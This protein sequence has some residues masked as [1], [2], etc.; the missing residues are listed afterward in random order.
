MSFDN[1][2]FKHDKNNQSYKLTFEYAKKNYGIYLD[3]Y[4]INEK[5]NTA[6][7]YICNLQTHRCEL[8]Y[9]PMND[10]GIKKIARYY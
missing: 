7:F 3:Y 8:S 1:I 9:L 2:Q 5:L 6:H 4:E 10:K